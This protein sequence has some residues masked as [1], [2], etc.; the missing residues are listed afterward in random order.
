MDAARHKLDSLRVAIEAAGDVIYAWD[1]RS[2]N[3]EWSGAVGELFRLGGES[4]IGQAERFLSRITPAGIADIRRCHAEGAATGERFAVSYQ[5]KRGDDTLTWIE[6]RG[7]F[8][9]AE[10]GEPLRIIGLMRCIDASKQQALQAARLAG[11]D[12]LTGHFNRGRLRDALEHALAYSVRHNAGGCFLQIGI[13]NLPL[14]QDTYGR[15]VAEQMV[16]AV[17]R[18][19]DRCLRASDVIGRIAQEEFGI[20]LNGCANADIS[21][22]AEKIL[23]AVRQA[24]VI[25]GKGYL[26]VTASIGAVAFPL[27]ARTAHDAMAKA[28]VALEQ[29]RRSGN[30][31]YNLYNLSPEQLTAL[32][33]NLAITEML[34]T[35]MRKKTLCLHFQPLVD[36]RTRA[37]AFYEC[38]LRAYDEN[39]RILQ[40]GSF[41]PIA[42]KM[43]LVRSIDR[44]VLDL[45]IAEL[46][47]QPNVHLAMNISGLSTTD[48]SWLRTLTA[49]V[50]RHSAIAQRLLVEITETTMLHDLKETIRFVAA[51]REMG[52]RVALDDFGAGYTSFRHLQE[53]N[54]DMVKIDGSF[55]K[56][57]GQN[58]NARLF[59]Q[60][61]QSFADGLGLKTVAECIETAD[62]AELAAGYGIHYLQG[63]HFGAPSAER[64]WSEPARAENVISLPPPP[65]LNDPLQRLSVPG[66]RGLIIPELH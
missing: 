19:L 12:G 13:D 10:N 24:S 3:V 52:V 23:H 54:V 57:L 28:A 27:S 31:C 36:T 18:E 38:L 15:D 16:V 25:T 65:R 49:H 4:E 7:C 43:G 63:W 11:F 32:R 50:Q 44:M 58:P 45:V 20:I 6:D 56:V 30:N 5:V 34:Q 21:V 17:S 60:T 8:E 51:L 47:G 53:L 48:P 46:E 9:R 59:V 66:P 1:V 14:I 41:L 35:A 40:A 62:L 55:V 42:E 22:T 2:G 33:E 39:G 26:P 61:L 37:P 29:A 64:Q